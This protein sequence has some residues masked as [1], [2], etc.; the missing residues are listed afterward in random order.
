MNSNNI[1][2]LL[3][4]CLPLIYEFHTSY[5]YIFSNIFIKHLLFYFY[6]KLICFRIKIYIND[7]IF[8]FPIIKSRCGFWLITTIVFQGFKNFKSLF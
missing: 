5:H 1:N 6:Y 4:L 8:W 7:L 3:I 2:I